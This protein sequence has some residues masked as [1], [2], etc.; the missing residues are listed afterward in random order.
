MKRFLTNFKLTQRNIVKKLITTVLLFLFATPAFAAGAGEIDLTNT[1]AGF[2]ALTIFIIAYLLVISEEFLHLRKSKPVLVAAGVIWL[3]IGWIYT[4][5]GIP[6]AAEEA[7]NHNLLEYAQ[8]L[9]F[10]LVAM[11][12][13]NAMEER[14]VFDS[15]RIWMISKGLSLRSLFWVTGL[16][17]FVISS[18][19]NNLTTAMLMCAIVLKVAPKDLKFINI[20]CIN[21]VVASNAGGVFS[22]FG[23]ITTLMIW[24]AELVKFEQFFVLF[25]PSL[26]NFLVPAIIMSFFISNEK[27]TPITD[28]NFMLK[29]GAKR[30]IFLFMLTIATSVATHSVV[31]M[32]PVLGMMMGLGYLKFLGFYLR[33]SLPRSLDKKRTL[34]TI[35]HDEKALERLG[36][37][38]PFDIFEKI[39]RAEWDTLLFFYGVVM[40]VGGLGFMGYLSLVSDLLY[41]NWDPTYANIAVGV[42]SAIID[43]IPVVFAVLSMNPVMDLQQ[44]LLVTMTAGV[45]GSLLSVGS[46]AG[47]ALMGQTKGK[48]SFVGHLK[49]S[50]AIALGYSASIYVH[51]LING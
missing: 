13:I 36:N 12:Y 44:W 18:F 21:I 3:I 37:I 1:I 38:V 39:A 34:A 7:F 26:V 8:L 25:I 33:R 16:M 27:S 41:T 49:W 29:R 46:A 17:A 15:L 14:G 4:Q 48:Y 43:N 32:P 35:S 51:F 47:V 19:A 45:G 6:K 28:E 22:P 24:Q 42:L 40:C 11:T 20:A 30:I 9:L 5:H 50:W 10:L 2:T 23:D 31:N